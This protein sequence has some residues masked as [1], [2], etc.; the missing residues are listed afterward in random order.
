LRVFITG[1]TGFVGT[2]LARK[3]LSIGH[4]VTVLTR[5]QPPAGGGPDGVDY[6]Q[7]DPNSPGAWQDIASEHDTI[8][9]LAGRSIFARWTAVVKREIRDSRMRIT[10]NVVDVIARRK[11]KPKTLINA[12]AVGYYG[13]HGDE[14]LDEETPPGSDFLA[15]VARDWEEE[16][17]EARKHGARVALCRFGIVLG[18]RG[19]ALAQMLKTYRHLPVGPLGSGKQWF[20]WIHEVDLVEALSFVHEHPDVEG[21]VNCT[22]PEPSR[23]RD[24]MRALAGVLER[25]TFPVGVPGFAL[26]I[27][28]GEFGKVLL[29]GQRVLPRKLLDA[30]FEFGFPEVREALADLLRG[31]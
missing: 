10:R 3:F 19:G 24:F 2:T 16:A 27:A 11:D 12:S 25:R 28:M 9:N 1:G 23:N 18:K 8:V 31:V 20:S 4:G 13:F 7:G 21:P 26:G 17:S 6:A 30:G 22:S 15:S 29:E 5:R 14:L